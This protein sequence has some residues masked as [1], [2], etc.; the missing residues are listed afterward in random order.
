[1]LKF[2]PDQIKVLEASGFEIDSEDEVATRAATVSLIRFD[3]G[4]WHHVMHIP[5][6]SV[7]DGQTLDDL[8]ACELSVAEE[9]SAS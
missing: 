4:S 7:D 6:N 1:M 9:A 8:L 3:D 2:T 5:D